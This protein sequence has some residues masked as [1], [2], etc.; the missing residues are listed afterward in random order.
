M[1]FETGVYV[2]VPQVHLSLETSPLTELAVKP[3]DSRK[4]S[5]IFL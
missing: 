5:S 1:L 4:M 2:Y 3:S